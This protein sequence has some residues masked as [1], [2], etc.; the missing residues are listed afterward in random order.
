MASDP[1]AD[2]TA[3]ANGE[4]AARSNGVSIS[5]H[6]PTLQFGITNGTHKLVSSVNGSSH[7]NKF[8]AGSRHRPEYCG[9]DP[10]E[11]T[12][13]IMQALSDL[14]YHNTASSLGS[15]SGLELENPTVSAFKTAVLSGSWAEAEQLLM[16]ASHGSHRGNGIVL[17]EGVNRN[18]MRC[19]LRQQKFL[20]LLEQQNTA[21]ALVVLRE[22]LA[23]MAN[24]DTKIAFLSSLLMCESLQDLKEQTEWDGAN[25][26]SRRI[27]LSYLSREFFFSTRMTYLL[28]IQ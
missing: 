7:G 4:L 20:E 9:H 11:V 8:Q 23:P 12:R 16:G 28:T 13:L 24:N 3:S 15:E 19:R 1:D 14:G 10:E 25:G 26:E 5:G 27:L 17:D 22:E 2:A 21:R 18:E 6:Q